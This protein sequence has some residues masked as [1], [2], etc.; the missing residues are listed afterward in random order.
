LLGQ[1]HGEKYVAAH[2][3]GPIKIQ[4]QL[5]FRQEKRVKP[6]VSQQA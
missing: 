6:R 1:R 3:F 5:I 4:F 2:L